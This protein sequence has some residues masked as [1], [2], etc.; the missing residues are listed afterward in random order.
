MSQ[1]R[2][3]TRKQTR[4]Y[5]GQLNLNKKQ[6]EQMRGEKSDQQI[7]VQIAELCG[8]ANLSTAR[9][10]QLVNAVWTRFGTAKAIVSIAIVD[11]KRIR[12]LNEQFL[13]RKRTT[14]VLSFNLSD[15]QNP[16]EKCFEIIV[17]AQLAARCAEQVQHS[18]QD[19]LALYIVHGLLHQ[20]GFDDQSPDQA[21]KM[22][23][24]EQQILQQ[25]G[26]DF[27]YN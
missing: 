26:Y 8:K 21:R 19:E 10:E 9:I 11:D 20:L 3:R 27:V 18:S 15:S 14:D 13:K 22:H 24:T 5:P 25:L 1:H 2:S 6:I 23:Q 12:R 17:N 4:S 7:T 16:N